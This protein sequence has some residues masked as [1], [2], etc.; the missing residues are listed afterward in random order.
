MLSSASM[1][2]LAP[3]NRKKLVRPFSVDVFRFEGK[4]CSCRKKSGDCTF[5]FVPLWY[6]CEQTFVD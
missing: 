5:L 3:C 4:T 1:A 2:R 6:I